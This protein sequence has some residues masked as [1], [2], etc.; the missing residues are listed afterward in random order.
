MF[1][2]W[3][4]EASRVSWLTT[5]AKGSTLST[6]WMDRQPWCR[7]VHQLFSTCIHRCWDG[8]ALACQ[9]LVQ[10]LDQSSYQT[11]NISKFSFGQG[12]I[13]YYPKPTLCGHLGIQSYKFDHHKALCIKYVTMLLRLTSIHNY[14]IWYWH[15]VSTYII[16]HG[17]Q[18]L[19]YIS[20]WCGHPL[21][22]NWNMIRIR[23]LQ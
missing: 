14:L 9:W 18:F 1:I 20:E 3:T 6:S 11:I 10:C 19:Q 7:P 5:W 21:L 13:S 23:L 4:A 22:H 16:R 12:I 17:R 2:Y 8:K 15:S